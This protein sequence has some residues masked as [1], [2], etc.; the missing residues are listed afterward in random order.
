MLSLPMKGFTHSWL[1]QAIGSMVSSP[2][3]ELL[4]LMPGGGSPLGLDI[5]FFHQLLPIHGSRLK[6]LGVQRL[7]SSYD[8]LAL[9]GESCPVLRTLYIHLDGKDV[10]SKSD[11]KKL[12]S[13]SSHPEKDSL[14]SYLSVAMAL[15]TIQFL[16]L[17]SAEDGPSPLPSVYAAEWDRIV[18]SAGPNLTYIGHATRVMKVIIPAA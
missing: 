18:G 17:P 13:C 8:A 16:F 9:I 1:T 11:N 4:L 14:C 2:I 6:T 3:E 10:V 7:R 12:E 15:H 5:D